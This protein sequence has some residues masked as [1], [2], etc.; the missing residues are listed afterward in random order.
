MP[1]Q[2]TMLTPYVRKSSHQTWEWC[3]QKWFLIYGLGMEDSPNVKTIYGTVI[4]RVLDY[5]AQL[6]LAHQN[7]QDFLVDDIL[8]KVTT[9]A[10]NIDNITEKIYKF[11][12]TKYSSL[13]NDQGLDFVNE[14]VWM[15][16]CDHNGAFNPLQRHIVCTEKQFDIPLAFPWAKFEHQG[17]TYYY[18]M[19]GTIDLCTKIGNGVAE[20][21]DWKSGQ[22]KNWKTNKKKDIEYLRNDLELKFYYYAAKRLYP[23]FH[24]IMLT[25]YF[26]NDG[27]PF[28]VSYDDSNL[29]DVEET[30]KKHFWEIT[31]TTFPAK[32]VGYWC[33]KFCTFGINNYKGTN[34]KICDLIHN[35]VA[36]NG[37]QDVIKQYRVPGFDPFHYNAPGQ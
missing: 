34:T 37:I 21:I 4:H 28:T 33:K 27:G 7:Q 17:E 8:G 30:L 26:T 1:E 25:M 32:S 15:A 11:F 2:F 5:L 14:N 31:H 10:V 3:H 29:A 12:K 20:I 22:R 23:D 9:S 16:I 19:K 18:A 13:D 36:E 24:T 35:K 6:K